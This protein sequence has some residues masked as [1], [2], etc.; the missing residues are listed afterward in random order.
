MTISKPANNKI[1]PDE[2]I[3]QQYEF[4]CT[5]DNSVIVILDDGSHLSTNNRE[6]K[7]RYAK[8]YF[9]ATGEWLSDKELNKALSDAGLKA[10]AEAP[11]IDLVDGNYVRQKDR[12]IFRMEDGSQYAV[13]AEGAGPIARTDSLVHFTK[14][15]GN[16]FPTPTP[17]EKSLFGI[18]SKYT[19][20]DP[21]QNRLLGGCL[22]KFFMPGPNPVLLFTGPQGSGKTSLVNIFRMIVD[23]DNASE[24]IQILDNVSTINGKLSDD[25]CRASHDRISLVTTINDQMPNQDLVDRTI[26]FDL[27]TIADTSREPETKILAELKE[28]LPLIMWWLFRALSAAQQNYQDVELDSYPRLADFV[29]AVVAAC[30]GLGMDVGE[31]LEILDRN[32][33][34]S[35]ER[36]LNQNPVS[37]AILNYMDSIEEDSLSGTATALLELL[38]NNVDD[39]IKQHS[40]WP[41]KPNKLSAML[42]RAAP[43]LMTRGLDIQWAKSGQRSITLIKLQDE[44]EEQ[45]S[46]Q[47]SMV[48]F[49]ERQTAANAD[50][51]SVAPV[52]TN[53]P[54][55]LSVPPRSAES[56]RDEATT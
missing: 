1:S 12:Y 43:F 14:D 41:S 45:E 6:F 34:D 26:V 21:E 7:R 55:A 36:S 54:G 27:E 25:L 15:S 10:L 53:E 30:P 23:P 46:N 24:R 11:V 56:H 35:V 37:A 44:S 17:T 8:D 48:E 31:F 22:L 28:D 52:S 38:N 40:N 29:Q 13:S 42:N 4:F 19:N 2:F 9:H 16:G 51:E 50:E 5:E 3:S 47:E 49:N 20:T 33:I 18:F 39:D 32:R